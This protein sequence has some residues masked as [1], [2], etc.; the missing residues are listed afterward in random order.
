VKYAFTFLLVFIGSFVFAQQ[1]KLMLM[2]RD[3]VVMINLEN[4]SG[5]TIFTI[6]PA[7]NSDTDMLNI[8]IKNDS[9][10]KGWKRSFFVYDKS[11]EAVKDFK[12]LNQQLFSIRFGELKKILTP[13][14]EYFI[15][16]TAIPSDPQQA[17]L[18]KPGRKL[19]CAIKIL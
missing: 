19:V 6:N 1:E 16:T 4:G 18:V 8:R 9:P 14:T 10:G 15:Y 7:N 5:N 17:M 13:Q 11:G 12:Q 3:Q 2:I